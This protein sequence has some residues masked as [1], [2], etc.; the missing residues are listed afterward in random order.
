MVRGAPVSSRKGS[1]SA[2]AAR[3]SC[4]GL[5]ARLHRRSLTA[6]KPKA[7]TKIPEP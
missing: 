4:G 5:A 6:A 7:C 1:M 2:T 3:A